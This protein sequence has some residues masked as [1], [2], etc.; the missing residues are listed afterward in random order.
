MVAANPLLTMVSETIAV[1]R[2]AERGDLVDRLETVA[3]RVRDPRRRIVVAGLGN[4]GKSRFVNALINLD[5]CPVADD[6]TT[7]VTT[8][9]SYGAQPGATVIAAGANGGAQVREPVPFDG[10][11]ALTGRGAQGSTVLSPQGRAV[12]RLEVEAPSQ[13]LADGIVVVDT[14]GLCGHQSAGAASILGQVPAA[15]AVLMLTDASTELTEAE[16]DFL[17]QVR[18]LCPAVA[19]LVT[20][21]DLY[22]H[23]RQVF[24]ANRKHLRANDL[25]VPILP[26]SAVLRA[27]AMRLRDEGLGRESGFGLVFQFLREQVV[28]RDQAALRRA[29]ALDVSSAAEHLALALGS[30]LVALR[31]PARGA[32]AIRELHAAKA[33]AEKL[34]RHTAAWQQ[35]LGDGITD[36]AGDID[37]DLRQRLRDIARTAEDWIDAHDPGRH[38]DSM[39]EWLTATVGSAVGDNLVWTGTRAVRLAEHVATHFTELGAVDLPELRETMDGAS[40]TESCTLAN[41]EPDLGLGHKLL[42]GVRGSYGGVVMAGMAGTMAGLALINP[43]SLGAGVLLGGK[44]FSDDKKARL[45]KR[46]ADAK[47]AVRRYLDDVAFHTGKETKDRLHRIHRLLRDHFT[48]VADRTLR[49]IDESLRAAQEAANLEAARRTERAAEL[50]RRLRVVAELR[51]HADALLGPDTAAA[52]PQGTRPQL[53]P[54]TA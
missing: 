38:W 1:A 49:S 16:V 34:H 12:L 2:G 22:P 46:R 25:E 39:D 53:P 48:A 10:F 47:L 6:R 9:L 29:V 24:E 40:R 42:V 17:R 26:V 32:A 13:L 11:A 8:V 41:L 27:H 43:L 18:E 51:R 35:T 15:D 14:P 33:E 20:K 21:I 3:S 54:P 7:A 36:L 19:V 52:S 37:H 30:E 45:A 50:E 28:A 44:A 4:Q 31:D 23:W 5:V